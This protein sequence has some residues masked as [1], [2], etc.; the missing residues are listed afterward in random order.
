MKNSRR[1]LTQNGDESRGQA[2]LRML[3]HPGG[4]AC[5]AY[6]FGLTTAIS[7]HAQP[8]YACMCVSLFLLAISEHASIGAILPGGLHRPRCPGLGGRR[9]SKGAGLSPLAI[10][11]HNYSC[12]GGWEASKI[13][14]RSLSQNGDKA[15][16]R[17]HVMSHPRRSWMLTKP[18]GLTPTSSTWPCPGMHGAVVVFPRAAGHG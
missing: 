13:A 10:K 18:F 12:K 11:N 2:R 4:R 15:K 6:P 17:R 14:T 16:L 1:R 5:D 3:S 9:Y 8:Y 7:D